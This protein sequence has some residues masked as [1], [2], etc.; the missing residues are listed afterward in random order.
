MTRFIHLQVRGLFSKL[1]CISVM[2]LVLEF[3]PDKNHV[4]ITIDL[5]LGSG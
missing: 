2:L 3:N 5:T 4:S 1:S